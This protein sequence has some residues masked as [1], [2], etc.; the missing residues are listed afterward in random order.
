MT[1]E[2]IKKV[3]DYSDANGILDSSPCPLSKDVGPLC[4]LPNHRF[5]FRSIHSDLRTDDLKG[6]VTTPGL[7][8]APT[9]GGNLLIVRFSVRSRSKGRWKFVTQELRCA[10]EHFSQPA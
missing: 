3:L 6:I 4:V 1:S 2:S 8:A 5:I 9:E 7:E 10:H